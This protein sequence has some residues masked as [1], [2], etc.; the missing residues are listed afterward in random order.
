MGF[1]NKIKEGLSKSR[2]SLVNNINSV[3]NSFTKID[4]DLFLTVLKDFLIVSS[5]LLFIQTTVF[6]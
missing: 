6:Y 4:E 5:S 3:I 2:N 1:F